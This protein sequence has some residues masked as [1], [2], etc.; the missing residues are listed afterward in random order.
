MTQIKSWFRE[1]QTLAIFLSTQA[2][3]LAIGAASMIA[4]YVKMET[5]VD[6]LETRGASYTVDRLNKIDERITVLEQQA[7]KNSDQIDKVID[8]MTRELRR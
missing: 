7:N 4:Y 3:A 1:N 8:I 2:L 5:R 6:I